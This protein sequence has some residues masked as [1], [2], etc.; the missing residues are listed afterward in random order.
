LDWAAGERVVFLVM[1]DAECVKDA[2]GD[3][4]GSAAVFDHFAA[5]AVGLSDYLSAADT[6]AGGQADTPDQRSFARIGREV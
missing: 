2:G 4:G 1:V 3:V 5:L 6:T